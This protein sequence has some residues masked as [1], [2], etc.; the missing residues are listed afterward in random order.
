MS[1]IVLCETK[2]AMFPYRIEELGQSF[3]SYEELCY[4]LDHDMIYFL[5][6]GF[7]Q[8]IR[9]Y[10]KKEL[11]IVLKS[12]DPVSQI[13]EIMNYHN[14]F[15]PEEKIQF[16]QRLRTTYLYSVVK[17]QKLMADLYLRHHM[18][19]SAMRLYQSLTQVRIQLK[20]GEQLQV[21][22]NLGLCQS[23]MF[24]FQ[25]AKESF[26]K[27]LE[28][29]EQ[30]EIQEAYFMVSYLQGDQQMFLRDGERISFSREQLMIIY[31]NIKQ[32]EEE[33]KQEDEF[34]KLQ[35]INYHRKKA[36]D[37]M[38]HKL[39]KAILEKWKDEYKKEII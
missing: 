8:P 30:K 1:K 32:R 35:K 17:K 2:E 12:E 31:D 22:Y 11:G 38:A 13:K 26:Y 4:L 6:T 25:D 5:I 21:F 33:I 10:L 19:L 15:T 7:D 36:D 34:I 27:A 16:Q 23:R 37:M 14:Y 24:C 18:Y 3:Q 20:P 29:K 28:I 9:S 39:T